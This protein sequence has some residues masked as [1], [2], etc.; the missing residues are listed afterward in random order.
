[1]LQSA[2]QMLSD[3]LLSIGDHQ[4]GFQRN[5]SVNVQIFCIRQILEKKLIYNVTVHQLFIDFQ[6]AYVSFRKELLYNIVIEVSIM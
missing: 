2:Y 1:V 5:K 3:I 4:Y 6:K